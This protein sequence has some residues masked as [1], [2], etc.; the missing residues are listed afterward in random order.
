MANYIHRHSLKG[1]LGEYF[2]I[3]VSRELSGIYVRDICGKKQNLR[4]K[5]AIILLAQDE[6]RL[7]VVLNERSTNKS[8]I[9]TSQTFFKDLLSADEI[10]RVIPNEQ[11]PEIRRKN[12][13]YGILSSLYIDSSHMNKLIG[14]LQKS[15]Q[16]HLF[17]SSRTQDGKNPDVLT[18]STASPSLELYAKAAHLP[19]QF[20]GINISRSV[21]DNPDTAKR[22]SRHSR[23]YNLPYRLA[24][25]NPD[26]D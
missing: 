9:F 2:G 6:S 11:Y 8:A 14:L 17:L 18:F 26:S 12:L 4:K 1:P 23:N 10:L 22:I 5:G 13:I 16:V 19:L 24:R 15:E 25:T 7:G 21:E 3:D 20:E